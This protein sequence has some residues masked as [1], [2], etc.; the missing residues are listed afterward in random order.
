[1]MLTFTC[2]G[3]KRLAS[4]LDKQCMMCS[5]CVCRV[6][7]SPPPS[8]SSRGRGLD[9]ESGTGSDSVADSLD[10]AG[11]FYRCAFHFNP[12]APGYLSAGDRYR[13]AR[14]ISAG[15][16]ASDTA[17]QKPD[18]I[19]LDDHTYILATDADMD[20]G[21]DA[22]QGL[23]DVCEADYRLGGAC[24]RTYP[25]GRKREGPILWF[26]QFEYARG[27]RIFHLLSK[28][29]ISRSLYL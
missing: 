3:L 17:D 19:N 4:S 24:G 25:I 15:S 13:A 14:S 23:V 22:V 6:H 10:S 18:D 29:G 2:L 26:Q 9:A 5:F 21:P 20:F 12:A 1:M 27:E 8:Y 16:T 11:G 7:G 28:K